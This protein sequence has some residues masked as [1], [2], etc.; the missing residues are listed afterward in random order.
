M[1]Y[2]PY[3]SLGVCWEYSHNTIYLARN[4]FI[5]DYY[6]N[7]E[8]FKLF[9]FWITIQTEHQRHFICAKVSLLYMFLLFI[10]IDIK[11]SLII[12]FSCDSSIFCLLN[13]LSPTNFHWLMRA[14]WVHICSIIITI[15]FFWISLMIWMDIYVHFRQ[16]HVLFSY[17]FSNF[18]WV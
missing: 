3:M 2:L 14:R 15:H 18:L 4:L 1:K 6:S 16:W 7:L 11:N 13:F 9:I 17:N 8:T 5:L 10:L 12:H